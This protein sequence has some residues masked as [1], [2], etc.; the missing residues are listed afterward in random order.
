[1]RA[2]AG[3]GEPCT[4]GFPYLCLLSLT[5]YISVEHLLQLMNQY[6]DIII[7]LK[8]TVYS[9]ALPFLN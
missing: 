6:Q 2:L 3:H 9:D 7:N 8:R 5:P 4:L 1:M